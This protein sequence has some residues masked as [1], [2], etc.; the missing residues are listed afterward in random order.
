MIPAPKKTAKTVPAL[1]APCGMNC[2]LC[3]AYARERTACPGCRGDDTLKSKTCAACR[4]KNCGKMAAG[5]IRY[6][7]SCAEFPCARLSHMDKRYRTKYGMSVIENL[8]DIKK[9]GIRQFV[10]D[11]NEKWLC[12]DCG[13]MI[14]VHKPQCLSCGHT[15]RKL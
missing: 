11:Q 15:W 10:R 3:R 2:R 9:S 13:G 7:F 12:P 1:I 5:G 4:I 8:M 14:C 6:C